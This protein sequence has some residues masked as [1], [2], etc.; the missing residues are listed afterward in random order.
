MYNNY[1]VDLWLF[2]A[3]Q[4]YHAEKLTEEAMIKRH[5][6]A[7][8]QQSKFQGRLLRSLG[9]GLVSVGLKLKAQ[10]QPEAATPIQQVNEPSMLECIS[11]CE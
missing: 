2:K 10:Y 9:A 3:L 1:Q 4:D 8:A 7:G 5:Q 11:T 6:A